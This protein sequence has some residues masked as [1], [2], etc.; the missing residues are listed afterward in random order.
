MT[1]EQNRPKTRDAGASRREAL[2]GSVLEGRY[3]V[4]RVL[5]AGGMA[6]V[7]LA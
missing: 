4:L 2:I 7:Y 3:R 6:E 1:Q 5:G